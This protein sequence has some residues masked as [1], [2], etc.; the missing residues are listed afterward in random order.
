MIVLEGAGTNLDLF[1]GLLVSFVFNAGSLK[2]LPKYFHVA[3]PYVSEHC[4]EPHAIS[5]CCL[6]RPH[7]IDFRPSQITEMVCTFESLSK[8]KQGSVPGCPGLEPDTLGILFPLVHIQL[9]CL[10]R[11]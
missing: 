7:T 4:V 9:Y 1:D 8:T 10:S 11:V 5:F 3:I 2:S 6:N